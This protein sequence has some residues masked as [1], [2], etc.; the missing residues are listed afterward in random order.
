MKLVI[1]SNLEHYRSGGEIVGAW[2]AAVREVDALA[3]LFDEVVHVAAL[4]PGPPPAQ[5][6][7]YGAANVRLR[8]FRPAG[9]SGVWS[10]LEAL[11][12]WPAR[13]AA[14]Q[15]SWHNADAALVR[16]PSNAASAAIALM[17]VGLGPPRRW[18]K[19]TGP[20]Q[21]R[22]DEKLGYKIQRLW[23]RAGLAGA[24]VTV[25]GLDEAPGRGAATL[26]N[27]SLTLAEVAAADRATWDKSVERPWRL[28]SA[29]RLVASK[30][31]DI[32][33]R[34]VAILAT[35]GCD[36]VLDI[37][38][39]GPQQRTLETL[40]AALGIASRV[41]FHGWLDDR[42]LRRLYSQAHVLLSPSR[43]E[44]WSRAWTEA[45]ARRCV[46]VISHVGAARGLERAAAGMVIPS[47][48]PGVW[49]VRVESLL[50]DEAAWRAFADRGPAL[51]RSFTYE[52]FLAGAR[53]VLRLD[54][55]SRPQEVLGSL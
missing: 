5:A 15:G 1:V 36:A 44:G 43:G 50:G 30:G 38:G 27:P 6:Q 24:A 48:V 35:R 45:A 31:V 13:A 39:D 29:G 11:L 10:K 55:S 46:P 12:V 52:E 14:I 17:S 26:C 22:E 25:G 54:E 8:L 40:A 34:T 4:H 33:L 51:A 16:C 23:L 9:G 21:G 32:A 19:Y 3:S 2:P 41:R 47:M 53:S 20:W 42:A 28:L 49:A 7:A 37:A 18:V